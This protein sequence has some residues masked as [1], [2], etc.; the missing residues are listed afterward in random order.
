MLQVIPT[1]ILDWLPHDLH[2]EDHAE[3]YP[4]SGLGMGLWD[5]GSTLNP[6][7]ETLNPKTPGCQKASDLTV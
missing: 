2:V 5:S 4:T 7:P 3:D 6:K 1:F